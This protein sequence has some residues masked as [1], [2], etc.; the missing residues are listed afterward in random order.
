MSVEKLVTVEW[1]ARQFESSAPVEMPQE[2]R[3]YLGHERRVIEKAGTN[4]CMIC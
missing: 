2:L 3:G 1:A 4:G